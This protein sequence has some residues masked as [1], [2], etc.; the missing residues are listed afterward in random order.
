M[1]TTQRKITKSIQAVYSLSENDGEYTISC[2]EENKLENK[3]RVFRIDN[4]TPSNI[5]AK[6]IY[7][8]IVKH[9]AL[10]ETLSDVIYNLIAEY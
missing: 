1:K 8:L 9:K 5:K 2:I 7:R 10:G 3:T 6:R 4:I